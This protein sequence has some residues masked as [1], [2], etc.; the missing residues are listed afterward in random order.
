MGLIYLDT[1]VILS[2]SPT[3]RIRASSLNL[4]KTHLKCRKFAW[5]NESFFNIGRK[6]ENIS[7]YM[8]DALVLVVDCA[9]FFTGTVIQINGNC[10]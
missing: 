5:I 9:R 6:Y 8:Y 7:N 4:V 1:N 10:P 2:Y 3:I